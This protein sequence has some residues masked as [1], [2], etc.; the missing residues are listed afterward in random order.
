MK[1]NIL[2][3]RFFI[4]MMFI[5][6]ITFSACENQTGET[7]EDVDPALINEN[8]TAILSGTWTGIFDNRPTTLVITEQTDSTFTGK[9]SIDYRQKIEQEVKGTFNPTTM[10][11]TMIDQLQ[12]RFQGTYNGSLSINKDNYSGTFTMTNNGAKYAFT[13]NKY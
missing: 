4:A 12:S 13:F 3:I 11:I 9:I 10:Q 1:K 5:A 6:A 8:T 2:F 7:T